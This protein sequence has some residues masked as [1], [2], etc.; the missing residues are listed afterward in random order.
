MLRQGFRPAALQE[1]IDRRGVSVFP[2][3][4]F[5]YE[6]MLRHREP[7]ELPA[8][9]R[10]CISAGARLK[11]ETLTA[12]KEAYG[13]KIHSFYG[14]SE[15]GGIAFD[16]SDAPGD[17]VPVGTPMPETNVTLRPVG[18]E[19]GSAVGRIH[20]AGNAVASGYWPPVISADDGFVDG[21]F[22]TGDLGH[23][24]AAGWLHLA[25]R[26]SEFVNVAGRKVSPSEVERVLGG[27]P[28][29][30]ENRVL[31][32]P[33]EVRGQKLVACVVLAKGRGAQL[34][35]PS[36]LV[37]RAVVGAQDPTPSGCASM[38]FRS[39]HVER[40]IG[41]RSSSWPRPT[42]VQI[43]PPPTESRCRLQPRHRA[44]DG[45]FHHKPDRRTV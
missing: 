7:A 9:L 18:H 10:L 16:A 30:Q 23:I 3:A 25:G 17:A 2:G 43:I 38:L 32:M 27:M 41:A 28:Q 22:L 14:T 33:C 13:L 15:T 1:D 12:F 24:D 8:G 6:H 45:S 34:G 44:S 21:G 35:Q 40:S 4:P 29:I 19:T 26:V 20:V 5:M 11:P 39:T 31:G 42:R 36:L 37:R